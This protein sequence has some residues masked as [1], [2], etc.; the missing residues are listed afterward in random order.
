MIKIKRMVTL[1]EGE[2]YWKISEVLINYYY[3]VFV[4]IY[5]RK[6]LL[7]FISTTRWFWWEKKLNKTKDITTVQN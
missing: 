3:V 6:C 4:N 2:H 7:F 5:N 1:K